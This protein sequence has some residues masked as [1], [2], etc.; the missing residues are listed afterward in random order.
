MLNE[1]V[2]TKQVIKPKQMDVTNTAWLRTLGL[3]HPHG[4]TQRMG[5]SWIRE[6]T[7]RYENFCLHATESYYANDS[8]EYTRQED[9][10]KINCLFGGEQTTILDG[11]G[12]HAH[13]RP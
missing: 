10:I 9:Y 6:H 3:N 12:Q 2:V 4:I 1:N 7:S 13:D 5:R 11:F 8:L